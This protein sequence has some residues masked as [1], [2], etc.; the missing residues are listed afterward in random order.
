MF[1]YLFTSQFY[2][3]IEIF[4]IGGYSPHTNYLF[5]GGCRLFIDSIARRAHLKM[6]EIMWTE[7]SSLSRLYHYLPVSS[8][9][10]RIVCSWFVAIMRVGLLH[11]WDLCIQLIAPASHSS[12]LPQTYG[13]YTECTRKYGNANV[14]TYFT[15]M[16]DFLTLS[17][18]IDDQIFCVHGGEFQK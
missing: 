15:D 8:C 1:R 17:T 9:D 10:I 2:D 13:F 5:L 18:V 7:D 16:F 4:R 14:W 11:K 12:L 6:Q 3:L